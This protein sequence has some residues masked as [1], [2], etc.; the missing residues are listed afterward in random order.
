V[1]RK[2]IWVTTLSLL[3]ALVAGAMAIAVFGGGHIVGNFGNLDKTEVFDQTLDVTGRPV[4]S[5]DDRNGN[6]T[7]TRGPEG[8]IVV[9]AIKRA[10]TDDSLRG[11]NIEVQQ[12]G[13]QVTVRTTGET[14]SGFFIGW[15]RTQVDYE[16]QMPAQSDLAPL[17]TSNG[18]ITITDIA[19]R[20]DLSSSNGT[21][22]ATNIG[23]SVMA[24]TSNGRVTI[25]NGRGML[26]LR[27]SNGTVDVQN[28]QAEGLELHTSNG[29]VTFSG[30]LAPGSHNNL[31]VGNGSVSLTLP[32][33]S[34]LSVDLRAGNGDVHINGFSVTTDGASGTNQKNAVRGVIGRADA[35]LIVRAGNGSI[36]LTQG[37]PA[38][39]VP[40]API[41]PTPPVSPSLPATPSA[42]LSPTSAREGGIV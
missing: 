32:P 8:K 37:T 11:L 13:N 18:A 15:R 28:V 6:V 2:W 36:T 23:G 24:Q 41:A 19:G 38:P 31:D 12:T 7:I 27:T 42:G 25:H 30:T 17:R 14:G 34:A 9:H 4:L 33:A 39:A 22:G 3:L 29:R 1:K 10:T 26:D 5:V 21:I 35:D 20:L 40:T 16:I